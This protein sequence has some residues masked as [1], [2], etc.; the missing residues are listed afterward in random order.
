[1]I[2]NIS[3]HSTLAYVTLD[4]GPKRQVELSNCTQLEMVL[5]STKLEIILEYIL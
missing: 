4:L 5:D 1:M 3:K 2:F